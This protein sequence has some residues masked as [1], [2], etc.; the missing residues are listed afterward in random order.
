[1]KT[2]LTIITL[3]GH[4]LSHWTRTKTLYAS[5]LSDHR[6][7]LV[8]TS[9][10]WN[11]ELR[12]RLLIFRYWSVSSSCH[13]F[14]RNSERFVLPLIVFGSASTNFIYSKINTIIA[15]SF[16]LNGFLADRTEAKVEL[17]ERLSSVVCLS[18]CLSSSVTDVMWLNGA[19]YRVYVAVDH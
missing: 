12:R 5:V 11:A 13:S 2:R 3:G 4:F 10:K 7:G 8:Y 1:M 14:V 17:I 18:V 9:A 16:S 19:R 6:V 15:F